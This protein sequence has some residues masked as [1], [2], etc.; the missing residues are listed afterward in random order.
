MYRL[1]TSTIND[2]FI[3]L[4][5]SIPFKMSVAGSE[6]IG[7]YRS[8]L[9]LRRSFRSP[10]I[11]TQLKIMTQIHFHVARSLL[12]DIAVRDGHRAATDAAHAFRE[13]ATQDFSKFP[14]VAL[15]LY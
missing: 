14:L 10:P 4:L 2:L 12:G 6:A 7:L 5:S 11:R 15:C 13:E 3:F 9:R 8:F 1:N